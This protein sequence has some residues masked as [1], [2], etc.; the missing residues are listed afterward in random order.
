MAGSSP[1]IFLSDF[2]SRLARLFLV[3]LQHQPLDP[4]A[5]DQMRL[6]DLVEIFGALVAVPHAL[7]VNHHVRAQ[8][9]AVEAARGIA[10]NALDAESLRLLAHVTAQLLS[11]AG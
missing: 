1:A 10:S 8:F 5:L 9:T 6:Q 7:G 3:G 11:T 2:V 4:A